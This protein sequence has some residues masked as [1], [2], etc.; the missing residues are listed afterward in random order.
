M[1]TRRSRTTLLVFLIVSGAVA[2]LSLWSSGFLD[3]IEPPAIRVRA[4]VEELH[5]VV[6]GGES[7][8]VA[9]VNDARVPLDF[10]P[11]TLSCAGWGRGLP[12]SGWTYF[13]LEPSQTNVV[14][15]QIPFPRVDQP[16][17]LTLCFSRP[18]TRLNQ[19]RNMV[20]DYLHLGRISMSF[21][22]PPSPVHSLDL[23]VPPSRQSSP[24]RAESP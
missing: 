1:K 5:D 21:Y 22:S 15:V 3:G 6:S 18:P 4:W 10:G 20:C 8:T 11:A 12:T 2:F 16:V 24:K 9:I 19:W 13:V 14:K 7:V 17:T 23:V